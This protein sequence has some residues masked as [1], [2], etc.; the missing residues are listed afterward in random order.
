LALEIMHTCS[1]SAQDSPKNPEEHLEEERI[2][3]RIK[4][5]SKGAENRKISTIG[6]SGGPSDHPMTT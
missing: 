1:S 6:N 4:S 3:E 2:E 5:K